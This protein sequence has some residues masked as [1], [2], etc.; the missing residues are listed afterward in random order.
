MTFIA[1]VCVVISLLYFLF[2]F[3][4]VIQIPRKQYAINK[5][6]SSSKKVSLIV[7]LRNEEKN[8]PLLLQSLE[9]QSYSDFE[10]ILIDDHSTDGTAD[11]MIKKA[12]ENNKITAIQLPES[13]NGKK[14]AIEQGIKT[15]SGEIILT[16]DADCI[17]P[18]RWIES[19]V[20]SF[21]N[22][23]NAVAGYVL[24]ADDEKWFTKF[25]ALEMLAIQTV[26]F[27]T[28]KMGFPI[29]I[30]GA[31]LSYQKSVFT[32]L[33]PYRNNL[34]IL[35]GDDIYFLQALKKKRKHLDFSL[36]PNLAVETK[37]VDIKN[38]IRQRIRWLKKSSSIGDL[39]S[40]L[41]GLLIFSASLMVLFGTVY[42]LVTLEF[43][44][45][46][47]VS[48]ILKMVIDFLLLFLIA[49]KFEKGYL[50]FHFLPSFFL[51]AFL[52]VFIVLFGWMLP[53]K[54]K[55]RKI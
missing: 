28:A 7:P 12:A 40:F 48:L 41:I 34:A 14:N 23:T 2:I 19:H 42:Q 6:R 11:R 16:T 45:L 3:F 39:S 9:S 10:I 15:A 5:T 53:V 51:T 38:Y 8:L 37:S 18:S 27:G 54:W 44:F 22:G 33:N 35:S 17:H 36:N 46:L 32:D 13:L 31:N 1:I 4:V 26:S 20:N 47:G 49:R 25:Q 50:L 52:T 21:D 29:G 43:N 55:H 30:S 24:I